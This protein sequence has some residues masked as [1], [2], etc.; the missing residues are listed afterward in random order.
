[1]QLRKCLVSIDPNIPF[2]MSDF[3][4]NIATKVSK[5][6]DKFF[7]FDINETLNAI[8]DKIFSFGKMMKALTIAG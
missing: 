2:R 3:L 5:L 8:K 7:D 6:F 4:M 1:M